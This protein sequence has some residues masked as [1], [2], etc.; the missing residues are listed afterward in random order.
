MNPP[1]TI[2]RHQLSNLALTLSVVMCAAISALWIQSV[3]APHWL[4]LTF[5]DGAYAI[6][7][8]AGRL[9][10]R[11]CRQW[12]G[13]PGVRIVWDR[14]FFDR[15]RDD[16]RPNILPPLPQAPSASLRNGFG[17]AR[18]NYR[19][20]TLSGTHGVVS[21]LLAVPYWFILVVC[22]LL[23]AARVVGSRVRARRVNRGHCAA[24]GYDL[25]GTPDRCPECGT[26]A[27]RNLQPAAATILP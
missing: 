19:V 12:G 18:E 4:N 17:F 25:R 2:L 1:Y 26:S 7:S 20:V 27:A 15:F 14:R 6:Q 13:P 3:V 8:A 11:S 23:L 24:C 21:D 22:A 16:P 9:Q 5:A 10:A